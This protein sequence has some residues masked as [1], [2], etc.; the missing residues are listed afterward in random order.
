MGEIMKTENNEIQQNDFGNMNIE[1]LISQAIE[2]GSMETVEKLLA[3]RRELKSEWAREEYFKD[4]SML[5]RLLPEIKNTK[6][7]SKTDKGDVIFLYAPIEDIIGQ[8][9]D[10]I[11]DY[12]FSYI[13]DS[14]SI[15][16]GVSVSIQVNHKCGHSEVRS[17]DLPFPTKTRIM[18]DT[19]LVGSTI[20][21]GNRYLFK[22]VF[23]ITT[24]EVDLD[25]LDIKQ[26]D[27][28][29]N[30]LK[31]VSQ[32]IK[33]EDL[34]PKQTI[35]FTDKDL[36]KKRREELL[37]RAAEYKSGMT[38]SEIA[39]FTQIK[40]DMVTNKPYQEDVHKADC[41]LLGNI[42][43]KIEKGMNKAFDEPLQTSEDDKLPEFLKDN[44]SD[45]YSI[46]DEKRDKNG[47]TL[48]EGAKK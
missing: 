45:E 41:L 39:H 14:K 33:K 19:Q 13:F 29:E 4:L 35:N 21:Y 9:K 24:G 37:K 3:V 16:G 42:I 30:I 10:I 48:F 8:T 27:E 36:A 26:E 25:S 1:K 44:K 28:T 34:P 11:S 12:G 40:N 5:Q 20:K 15:E 43:G 6:D 47:N 7:G 22:N 32:N 46:S 2:K 18:T 17:I 23:G 38:E 31:E